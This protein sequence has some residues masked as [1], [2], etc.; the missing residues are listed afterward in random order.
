[1]TC[2]AERTQYLKTFEK[3]KEVYK[4]AA[5]GFGQPLTV[6]FDDGR[7]D[8]F[9]DAMKIRNQI[10]HP[11]NV[12]DCWINDGHLETIGQANEWFKTL[13]NEFVRVARAHRK[14]HHW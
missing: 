2:M 3:I 4:A 10:T 13:T 1:M 14:V 8:T 6:T 11:K 5:N 12:E 7:S 9:Q